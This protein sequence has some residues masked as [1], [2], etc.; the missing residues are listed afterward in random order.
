[1]DF[2]TFK[3]HKN[4]YFSWGLKNHKVNLYRRI[5]KKNDYLC[6]LKL[7]LKYLFNIIF[8]FMQTKM[9]KKV[10]RFLI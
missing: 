9:A 8:P 6:D 2:M 7:K 10:E 1:M 3:S 4:P 5:T